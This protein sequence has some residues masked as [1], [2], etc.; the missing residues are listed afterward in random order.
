[1]K[2][3]SDRVIMFSSALSS[4]VNHLRFLKGNLLLMQLVEYSPLRL[5]MVG[6]AHPTTKSVVNSCI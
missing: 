4:S 5:F 1:M 3:N 6:I 2:S